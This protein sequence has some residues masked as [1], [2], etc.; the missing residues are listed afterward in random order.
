MQQN[1]SGHI[2]RTMKRALLT[3]TLDKAPEVVPNVLY[4]PSANENAGGH[5]TT[6][7][8]SRAQP[9]DPDVDRTSNKTGK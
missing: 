2:K 8:G 1:V 5:A 3:C 6:H 9:G 7:L 4:P